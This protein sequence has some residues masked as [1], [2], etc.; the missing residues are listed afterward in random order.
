MATPTEVLPAVIPS[1]PNRTLV[2]ASDFMPLLSVQQ[3]T[4][5]KSQI[6][7]FIGS[8]LKDGEDYGKMPGGRDTK[9]LLKPGAEKL[10]SIFGMS[11]QYGKETIIE[12]WTG[13][14]HG[15]EPLFYYEYRCQLWRGDRIMGEAI[16]SC[17]SWETKY[18]YRWIPEDQARFRPDFDKLPKRGGKTEVFEPA[19]A[20]EKRET[21]GKYGKPAEYWDM[22]QSALANGTGR[23]GSKTMGK[24]DYNGIFVSMDQTQYRVP[25]PEIADTINTLQKMAQKRSLVAAVLVVTNCSDAFTQDVEDFQPEAQ[26]HEPAHDPGPPPDMPEERTEAP[27]RET[28]EG[29]PEKS[30]PEMLADLTIA[31]GGVASNPLKTVEEALHAFKGQFAMVSVGEAKYKHIVDDFNKRNKNWEGHPV[32]VKILMTQ[33][34]KAL[35]AVQPPDVAQP[36]ELAVPK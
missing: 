27:A 21:S 20:I 6:N 12:D 19:F 4:D 9:I 23:R 2:Q 16:G 34:W 24:K 35:Q 30:I 25:N 17:N 8:V 32:M 14:A 28:R 22:F 33:L 36:G 18:R 3:A 31:M 10:C 13:A 29:K 5:R 1:Q 15:G 7:Q 11:P 26:H